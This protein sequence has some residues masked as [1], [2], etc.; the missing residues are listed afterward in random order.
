MYQKLCFLIPENLWSEKK[1][2]KYPKEKHVV[3]FKKQSIEIKT[4]N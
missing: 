4:L 1:K 2:W 3:G